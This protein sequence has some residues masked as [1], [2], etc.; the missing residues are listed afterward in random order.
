M[1]ISVSLT[2]FICL[3]DVSSICYLVITGVSYSASWFESSA[4]FPQ[5]GAWF[6]RE[7]NSI[8]DSLS[9]DHLLFLISFHYLVGTVNSTISVR[10]SVLSKLV[11][12]ADSQATV[13]YRYPVAN[14]LVFKREKLLAIS[15]GR[16]S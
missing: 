13:L 7:S 9:K 12:A 5:S 10:L 4:S 2:T 15:K 11:Q 16:S 14:K 3:E 1:T 8:K 6:F